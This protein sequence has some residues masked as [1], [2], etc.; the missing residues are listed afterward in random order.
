[1][2]EGL[3]ALE[4]LYIYTRFH[5]QYICIIQAESRY[6]AISP[7][8]VVHPVKRFLSRVGQF[9]VYQA[10]TNVSLPL[11]NQLCHLG[12]CCNN[13]SLMKLSFSLICTIMLGL[14]ESDTVIELVGN[15]H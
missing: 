2:E 12:V 1:M 14:A 6:L 7:H 11:V 5:D 13:L 3:P 10:Y 9:D 8:F 4:E 15:R